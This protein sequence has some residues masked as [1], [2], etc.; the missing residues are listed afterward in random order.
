MKSIISMVDGIS[1]ETLEQIFSDNGIKIKDEIEFYLDS[2]INKFSG[3]GHYELIAEFIING[4]YVEF[5][6]I[7]TNMAIPDEWDEDDEYF[8]TE[9]AWFESQEHVKEVALDKIISS[10][11]TELQ[12]LLT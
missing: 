9:N 7:T 11:L 6:M 12:E 5:S 3:Y 4:E 1:D 10:N 2:L 8:K